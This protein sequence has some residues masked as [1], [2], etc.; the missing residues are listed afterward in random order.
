MKSM[1]YIMGRENGN[2]PIRTTNNIG[3][4]QRAIANLEACR[5]I[6]LVNLKINGEVCSYTGIFDS[7]RLAGRD[8]MDKIQLFSSTLGQKNCLG[9]S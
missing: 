4:P 9:I 6:C 5:M 1:G 3:L 2:A 8:F 7:N